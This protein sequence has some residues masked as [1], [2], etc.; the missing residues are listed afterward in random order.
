MSWLRDHT[1]QEQV[2]SMPCL[3]TGQAGHDGVDAGEK[4]KIVEAV[5]RP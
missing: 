5:G 4:E 1:D 2:F 3:E